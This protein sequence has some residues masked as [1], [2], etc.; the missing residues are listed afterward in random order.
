MAKR[1]GNLGRRARSVLLVAFVR[2]SNALLGIAVA[3][4][5][6]NRLGATAPADAFFLV[7]RLII[8][9]NEILRRLII[10]VYVPPLVALLRAGDPRKTERTYR[11]QMRQVLAVLGAAVVFVL[12]GAPWMV[13]ALAPGF[14][15]ERRDTA[16]LL[17]R[18]FILSL[19]LAAVL[20]G[21]TSVLFA[22]RRF[23]I[24]EA[25][26]SLPRLL[27]IGILVAL[28]PPLGV[29][30][31]A[32][33]VLI[34]T[35]LAVVI[36]IPAVRVTI[37][38]SSAQES[39]SGDGLPSPADE[40][41]APADDQGGFRKRIIPVLMVQAYRHGSTWIDLA[42]A[43]TIA[44]GAVSVI[45][46]SQR[47]V[48]IAPMVLTSSFITV[49][50]SEL[51][52]SAEE[53]GARNLRRGLVAAL[54]AGL[55]VLTPVAT[56]IW[57]AAAPLVDLTL[58]HGAFDETTAT[59]TTTIIKYYAAIVPTAFIT[60]ILVIGAYADKELPHLR[61][62]AWLSGT[63]FVSRVVSLALLVPVLGI[64]GIPA[65]AISSGVV[66]GIVQHHS[67]TVRWGPIMQA[68]E[69]LVLGKILTGT[70]VTA[71]AMFLVHSLPF[72]G[73]AVGYILE[74]ALLS[75][76]GAAVYVGATWALRVEESR[77]LWA[78]VKR[79]MPTSA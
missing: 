69:F 8:G 36:L 63:G 70:A 71:G 62:A 60:R 65:A 39:A 74:L 24:A 56:F 30:A 22:S 15:V 6:A 61:I 40:D 26:N 44:A 1:V 11:M 57:F 34:G 48:F 12:V 9:V 4:L 19:P 68:R 79:L 37:R 78:V 2:A 58:R 53:G 76:V 28:V 67:L 42:F 49:F 50:Y 45:E 64:V 47:L 27:M 51:L 23:A 43:S 14:D 21:L 77:T 18:I 41:D 25:A 35:A 54:R 32:T 5:V 7:R 13:A 52:H 3:V 29:G 55:Y 59:L 17:L 75:S 31:L 46:Y 10:V 66:T 72:A 16:T 73:N 20:A 33:A 38:R